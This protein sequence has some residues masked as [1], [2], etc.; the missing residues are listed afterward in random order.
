MEGEGGIIMKTPKKIIDFAGMEFL[1]ERRPAVKLRRRA[2]IMKAQRE[3]DNVSRN[4]RTI[5]T[6]MFGL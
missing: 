3:S 5:W 2:Q 6:E 4:M 1:E